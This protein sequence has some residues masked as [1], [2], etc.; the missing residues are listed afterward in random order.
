MNERRNTVRSDISETASLFF[1]PSRNIFDC[2]AL[3]LSAQGA[4][5]A[6]DRL[7]ALPSRFLLSFDHL[8][9]ARNC[10]IVW[11]K[12]N[13]VGVQ[14]QEATTPLARRKTQIL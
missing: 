13:F 9:T 11:S 8:A 4:K 5:I 6:L 7:Y 10:R 14:F 1:S 2:A 3:D 12:G